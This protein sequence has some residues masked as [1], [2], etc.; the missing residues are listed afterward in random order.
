MKKSKCLIVLLTM[1]IMRITTLNAQT[2][3]HPGGVHTMADLDRIKTKVLAQEHPWIDGWNNMIQDAKAQKTYVAN[4]S[5]TIGGS[6]GIRQQAAR[7]ATAAYYNLLRWHVTG[8]TTYARCAVNILNAW[9]NKINAVVTGELFQLPI[10]TMVQAAEIART[11]PGWAQADI[12]KFKYMCLNYFYPACH[13]FIGGCG[14]WS[15]WDLPA[16]ANILYIGIF[17]DDQAKFNEAVDYYKNGTGGGS[18]L[19]MVPSVTG[20]VVEMGRDQPHAEIGPG[21]AA[22]FCQS[23]YNQGIDL[24]SYADNRLLAASEYYSKYNLNYPVVWT[25]YNDCSNNHFYYLAPFGSSRI[26]G[27]PQLEIIY[28]HFAVNKG[29]NVPYTKALLKLRGIQPTSGEYSGYN[30]LSFTLD[31]TLSPFTPLSIPASPTNLTAKTSIS[32]VELSWNQPAGDVASGY[33]I[34]RSTSSGSGFQ[35]IATNNFDI[36]LFYVDE[37]VTNGTTYYYRVAAINSAG[38]G[39]Y[40]SEV[41]VTPVNGS[42]TMPQDWA[43]RDI[44]TVPVTATATYNAVN[45]K[46]F[47]IKGTGSS[48]GGT[49][50]S[51]GFVYVNVSGDFTISGRLHDVDLSGSS[52]DRVGIVMRESFSPNATMASI[53][54]HD[55]G[56]RKVWFTRRTSTGSNGSWTNGNMF[57]SLTVW[58]KL[59]RTGNIFTAYQSRDGVTWYEVGSATIPMASSSYYAGLFV[60]NGWTSTVPTT[61][62]FDNVTTTG[63]ILAG[64]NTPI[65]P[66]GL[67]LNRSNNKV[68]LNW[69]A[70]DGAT[71]YNIKRANSSSGAY[72]TIGTATTNTYGDSSNTY[73]TANNVF[74]VVSAVNQFGESSNGTANS[75]SIPNKLSGTIIGTAGSW[76]NVATA[77]KEAA[78]DG[79]INTFFD[80]PVGTAWIGYDL[81]IWGSINK[82]RYAPRSTNANRMIGGVFQ[83]S[84]TADFSNPTT[85]YTVTTAPTVGVIT[86]QTIS[87]NTPFRYIRYLSPN[88]G[89]GNVAEVEFYG[90]LGSAPQITGITNAVTSVDSVF[91]YT[92][93]ANNNPTLTS[94]TSLPS[95]LTLNACTGLITGKPTTAGTFP[96]T[97]GASNG[98]GSNSTT[99]TITVK[100]NQVISFNQIPTKYVGDTDFDPQAI[101]S[102]GLPVSYISSDTTVATILNGKIHIVAAGSTTITALQAGNELYNKANSVSQ[103]FTV[104]K[105][106][107]TISLSSISAKYVDDADFDIVAIASSGLAVAFISSD[108]SVAKIVNGKVQ[109]I[110]V[111]TVTI[112]A[113][114]LG[115][116]TYIAAS[117]V[118]QTFTVL[119]TIKI[120][121]QDGDRNTTNNQIRPYL[122]L[123]NESTKTIPLSEITIRYWLTP[124]NYTGVNTFIDYTPLG[125]SNVKMTYVALPMP[126]NGALGYV[127]YSFLPTAGN[128]NANSVSGIIQSRLANTDWSLL[129]EN[130][131]YSWIDAS[132]YV[133][134]NKITAYR[135]GK[136]IW[137][138]EPLQSTVSQSIKIYSDSKTI[139]NSN[140]ISTYV[141]INNEGNI[142][143]D[144]K[145]IKVRY[146]FTKDGGT[147]LNVYFDYVKLGNGKVYGNFVNVNPAVQGGDTYF[148]LGFNESTGVLYPLS[149]SGNI[150]YRL[151]KSDWSN[152]NQTDDYSYAPN[153][154]LL[155]NKHITVYHKGVLI[156]GEEP[157]SIVENYNLVMR[158]LE[159]NLTANVYT[160]PNPVNS[161][162]CYVKIASDIAIGSETQLRIYN[163]SGTM[164]LDKIVSNSDSNIITIDLPTFMTN[165]VYLIQVNQLPVSKFILQR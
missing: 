34:Q 80:A 122:T 159:R 12:D 5:T 35:T 109:I 28:N 69:N 56:F 135:N 60:S 15:S 18:I 140:T 9:S 58:F 115:D 25:E 62:Y 129:S 107:Q 87:N 134:Q 81:G 104:S 144:Y 164:V 74:Y 67:N 102:A 65:T 151:A 40:S 66:T 114:Q 154:T 38:T 105:L 41:S 132:S 79:N 165:G 97:I 128:I 149:S 123:V 39:S 76:G 32:R 24:F 63:T 33:V 26:S 89:F 37:S 7:D 124:E 70:V 53:G 147:N 152:F 116:A 103:S 96:I 88:N 50:D 49:S 120:K 163:F 59:T 51:H 133:F 155:L 131:D 113:L 3:V 84:N 11:Y 117:E 146:W 47:I 99:M 139:A 43:I 20:Q 48:F 23:A 77:T 72:T 73:C 95:G 143:L 126:R 16:A 90:I 75:L 111:G 98:F 93:G 150:N 17:C 161:N 14:S 86:E 29:L 54:L 112:T 127:E 82:V 110:G 101:T 44:G 142:P 136:L 145:D 100:D 8:D 6:N 2:F 158:P 19:N 4:P 36:K 13:N 71:S 108:T 118:S 106:S 45:N 125:N 92:I 130:D 78:V 83:G 137:G 153:N 1:I 42:S 22:E 46:T 10:M 141:A 138:T 94:T 31:A 55:N 30:A 61:A 162:T 121:Y 160:Y 68:S 148:E 91:N 57:T 157:A 52:A 21:C 27:N 156:S 119:S 85:L 64:N